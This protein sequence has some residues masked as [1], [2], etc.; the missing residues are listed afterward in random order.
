MLTLTTITDAPL[1]QQTVALLDGSSFYM[2]IYYRSLQQGW[3]FNTITY[4]DFTLNGLRICNLSNMLYQWSEILPFGIACFSVGNREPSQLQ[5][6]S[7]GAS[8]LYV[9]TQDEVAQ[10]QNYIMMGSF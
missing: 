9:L 4:N 3:F 2:E 8:T 7:S 10:Y 1:Q 6:F 5:D